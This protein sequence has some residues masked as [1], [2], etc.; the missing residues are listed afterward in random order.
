LS[1]S[2]VFKTLI[3]IS[4]FII[5]AVIPANYTSCFS[6][7]FFQRKKFVVMNNSNLC[8]QWLEGTSG[9]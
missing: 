8:V 3:Y 6:R 2:N 9:L 7:Y 4:E 5:P 1:L